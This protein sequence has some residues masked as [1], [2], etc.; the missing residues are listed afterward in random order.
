MAPDLSNAKLDLPYPCR[1]VYKIIGEDEGALRSAAAEVVQDRE[2]S[3]SLSRRS[4]ERNYLSL[5]VEVVVHDEGD[6]VAIY[7]ALRSHPAVK[8]VL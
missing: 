1:W 8:L 2:H 3:I 7:D 4:A 6:R 5:N